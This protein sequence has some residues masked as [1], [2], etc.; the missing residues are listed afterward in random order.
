MTPKSAIKSISGPKL[1]NSLLLSFAT[2]FFTVTSFSQS[3]SAT[4]QQT[5][6]KQLGV[7]LK[8]TVVPKFKSKVF[9]IQNYGAVANDS[10]SDATA[11][12][13]AISACS[14]NGGGIVLVPAG[15]YLTAAIHL[16]DNVNLHLEKNSE[17]LFSTN[18]SDY[19][20]VHTSFEGTE[21]MNYSPLIYA[22]K[23]KNVA[24]SGQGLL[25]GQA[26]NTNWWWWCGKEEYGWAPGKPSQ[27]GERN[28]LN[29]VEMAEKLVPVEQRVFGEGHYLRPNFI[30][31]FD[32]KNVL[33]QGVKI[34]NAPFWVVHPIKSVNVTV[35]GIT[36]ESHGPNNDGCDPEYSKNVV[37]KNCTFNT[38]DDC[39]AIKAGRDGDGRRVGIKSE[40]IV[41][42][43]CK[44]IDGHGGVVI[45]SEIS[46]GVRN[47]FVENCVMDSPNLDRAIRIK[48]NSNRGGLIEN[49]FVRNLKVGQ[50]KEAVLKLNM[51]YEV[52]GAKPGNFIPQIQNVFLENITVKDGGQYAILA[53]G[54]ES[55]PIKNVVLKNVKIEK[56][57]EP[58]SIENL[59]G[60]QLIDTYING[61][62]AEVPN[63]K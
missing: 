45:G 59:K 52:Y 49:I 28:R 1:K 17:I 40:N 2:M 10:I 16:E 5:S 55:S 24:V 20:M 41:V 15:K 63:S 48:T 42:Q 11:F 8:E 57:K 38:G 46:A 60:L 34:V 9:N 14:S 30:E 32:C 44:M 23:K 61:V 29:L 54:Y 22:Y 12:K 37:I 33:L 21:L 56:V 27:N 19:P 53:K 47:V 7:I 39:I 13:K 62:K 25:N 18:P 3:S 36:V 43:N 6:W 35:D 50:V 58:F 31:F 26:N 4:E 51:F